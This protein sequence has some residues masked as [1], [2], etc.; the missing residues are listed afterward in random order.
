[1]R[2]RG[3]PGPDPASCL[4]A[5]MPSMTGIRTSIRTTSGRSS[6]QIR[7]ASACR[8]RQCR[9][10]RSPAGCPAARRTRC[11]PPDVVVGDNDPDHRGLVMLAGVVMQPPPPRPAGWPRRRNRRRE[12]SRCVAH[13]RQQQRARACRSAR[14]HRPAAA[15]TAGRGPLSRTRSR[16]APAVK[17]NSTSTAAPGACRRAL[18]RPSCTI[19]YVTS[20]TPGS[21]AAERPRHDEADARARGVPCLVEQLVQLYPDRG[22]GCRCT[23]ARSARRLRV[24]P[25]DAQQPPHL[26]QRRPGGVADRR[27]PLRPGRG[28]PGSGQPGGLRLHGDHGDVVGHDVVQLT[29]DACPLP[30]RRVLVQGA[31]VDLPGGTVLGGLASGPPGGPGPRGGQAQRDQQH[32]EDAWPRCRGRRTS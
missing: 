24:L 29:G 15:P 12:R 3:P 23:L 14:G 18:V 26:G 6:P 11:V 8:R 9:R 30:A 28:H 17:C 27:Q 4:V 31:C 19:R 2:M 21:R 7:T 25:Q 32:G 10:P 1:M 20:S 5:S 16:R 13:R 22:W